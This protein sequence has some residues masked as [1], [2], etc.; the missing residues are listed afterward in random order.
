MPVHNA[1]IAAVF[2]EIADLLE[3]EDANPFRI[4]AYRNAARVVEDSGRDVRAMVAAGEDL[5]DLP[6]IGADLAGKIRETVETGKS[7]LLERLRREVPPAIA[8]LLHVPNLGPKRVRLL[9]HDLGVQTLEQLR[10]AARDGRIRDVPG[11]GLKSERKI[12]E[13]VEAHLSKNRR[14]KLAVATQYAEALKAHLEEVAGVEGVEVAGSFRRRQ[15]TVGDLDI[16]VVAAPDSPA[17]AAFTGY[18]EVAEVLASGPT[19]ASVRLKSG[20]QVDLRVVAPESYGAALCYFTGSKAH[21]IALRGLAQDRGLKINEYGVFRE[22]RRIAGE[23]EASVYRALELPL[24]P[25][26]LREDR[27]EIQ[28]AREGR[29]PRLVEVA[30]LR[31]D[32]HAHTLATDGRDSLEDMARAAAAAG[33]HY[34]AIT[35]HS[36]RLTMAHGLGPERLARQIEE[37]DRMNENLKGIRLLK[38]IEVDILESGSLDLPDFILARLDVVV[39]AVHSRFDLSQ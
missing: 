21:G 12:L 38:G 23:S 7:S 35:D 32:L 13:A 25:P 15:E 6:G 37:I 10:R 26:E 34:L 33:L 24:I 39:G 4:R 18:D 27:G 2:N 5:T 14:F 1:D 20:L 31:G 29:L 30:D 16:L 9:W 28:A 17:M 36:R 3:M 22:E 11:F 19:R 8:E